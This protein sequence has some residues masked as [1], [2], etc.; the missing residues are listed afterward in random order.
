VT[1]FTHLNLLDV[2]APK[3]AEVVPGWGSESD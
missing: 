3:D 1:R 2:G